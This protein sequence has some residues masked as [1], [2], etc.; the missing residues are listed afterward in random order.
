LFVAG[1]CFELHIAANIT[2]CAASR[3][4][5]EL[6][7]LGNTFQQYSTININPTRTNDPPGSASHDPPQ[8][9]SGKV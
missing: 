3:T 1:G 5:D 2:R 6:C 8:S 9:N 7:V 4:R